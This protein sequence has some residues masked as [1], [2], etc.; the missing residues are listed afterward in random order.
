MNTIKV[1][2]SNS[3]KYAPEQLVLESSIQEAWR[4]TEAL[5][6]S[7]L[8]QRWGYVITPL[9]TTSWLVTS[10]YEFCNDMLADFVESLEQDVCELTITR[11]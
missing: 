5:V 9:S 1:I 6:D 10:E 4:N 8:A 3:R 2:N 7:R 11:Y